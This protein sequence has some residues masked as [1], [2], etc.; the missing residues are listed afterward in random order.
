APV[1]V[2]V[3]GDCPDP[4]ALGRPNDAARNLAAIGDEEGGEHSAGLRNWKSSPFPSRGGVRGGGGRVVR[5]G[6]RMAA[7]RVA[8]AIGV[9]DPQLRVRTAPH[10]PPCRFCQT[11]C[12]PHSGIFPCFFAGTTARLFFSVANA[13]ITRR[14]VPRGMMT[15]SMKP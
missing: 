1:G 12:P 9:P 4:E 11:F 3:D 13:R 8:H 7:I 15:S 6:G 10:F 5:R 14:R 2:G